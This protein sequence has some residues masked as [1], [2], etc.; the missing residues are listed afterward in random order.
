MAE[1]NLRCRSRFVAKLPQDGRLADASLPAKQQE[2][3]L[4]LRRLT[5]QAVKLGKNWL[6]FQKVHAGSDD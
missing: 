1:K 3:A 6:A 4:L 5:Q 2:R